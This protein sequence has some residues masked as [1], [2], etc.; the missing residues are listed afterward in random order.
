MR[1]IGP[2]SALRSPRPTRTLRIAS[3]VNQ[4]L[5][6]SRLP[7]W[8]NQLLTPNPD[9]I[10][11]LPFYNTKDVGPMVLEIPPAT[12]EDS[13]TGSV[14]DAWQ[15]ALEDVGPA[16]VDKGK[17]GKYLILPPGYA[18]PVPEGYIPLRSDTHTGFGI[19]RANIRTTSDADVAKAV[20][21]GK[22]V[23]FY[24]LAQAANP[25]ATTFVDFIGTIYDN[26]IPYDLSFFQL[27]DRFVQREPW[28]PRDRVMIDMLKSIGIEKGKPFNPDARHRRCSKPLCARRRRG[29]MHGTTRRSFRRRFM[30]APAGT[31]RPCPKPSGACPPTLPTCNS[32]P[33]DSRGV[34][35][36]YA[37]F[38]AK[39]LGEGQFYLMAIKDK[40]GRAFDGSRHYRLHVPANVPVR[41]YWSLTLHDRATHAYIRDLSHSSRSS[42]VAGLQKNPDGSV[43]MNIGPK[44]PAGRETNWIPTKAGG[45]FEAMLRFY[46]PEKSF[47]D[48]IWR[49]ADIEEV[50]HEDAHTTDRY[51]AR[52][53]GLPPLSRSRPSS[54]EQGYSCH[55]Q[56][57][58]PCRIRLLLQRNSQE[59]W[60]WEIHS[61][62]R[63]GVYRQTGRHS[64]EPR[65]ALFLGSV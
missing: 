30:Q 34:T 53:G 20:A 48:K 65:H 47:F 19:L 57:F 3:S 27:L 15:V 10:Y 61:S 2:S 63:T 56:Q 36:S 25:P 58:R 46:G 39:H 52:F 12:A 22:R 1:F 6:W 55:R 41:L 51:R 5:Y 35:Y 32:Y 8:K 40:A 42:Q 38:S 28:L 50:G 64:H 4:I 14:D 49:L 60:F 17:G 23:K 29:S 11:F 16:G 54:R 7:D 59:R 13:I 18:Q 24:P 33:V 9:T 62:P 21:Y 37:I 31:C 26:T 44:A 43:D 45:R